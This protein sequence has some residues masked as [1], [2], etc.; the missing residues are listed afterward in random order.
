MENAC[1]SNA[2]Q[3]ELKFLSLGIF[4]FDLFDDGDGIAESEFNNYVKCIY[5]RKENQDYKLKS[6]GYFGEAL[7]SLNT[8]SDLT[9]YTRHRDS[10][11]GFKLTF[12][13][14]GDVATQDHVEIAHSGTMITVRNIHKDND[15]FAGAFK[16]RIQ[17][18]FKNA[19]SIMSDLTMIHH[20][21]KIEIYRHSKPKRKNQEYF[22]CV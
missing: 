1:C 12:D 19:L 22:I 15:S 6:L 9:V 16:V 14:N 13:E 18:H 2:T 8:I 21:I 7:W 20:D 11:V 17:K 3:I 5:E 10:Q 4:G